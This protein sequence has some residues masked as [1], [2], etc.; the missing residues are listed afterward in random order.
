VLACFKGFFTLSVN[1]THNWLT[2][3]ADAVLFVHPVPVD[4]FVIGAKPKRPFVFDGEQY[5]AEY[6]DQNGQELEQYGYNEQNVIAVLKND[7]N[8]EYKQRSEQTVD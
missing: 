1:I 2:K 3:R 5:N 7:K 8:L 4:Q 6:P